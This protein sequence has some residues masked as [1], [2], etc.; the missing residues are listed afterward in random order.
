TSNLL[1]GIGTILVACLSYY[2]KLSQFVTVP[3]LLLCAYLS[4]P[5]TP[6]PKTLTACAFPIYLLHM[7]PLSLVN[8]AVKNIPLLSFLK[9]SVAGWVVVG[10]SIMMICIVMCKGMRKGMPNFS[11]LLFGGR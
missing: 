5:T 6:L 9:T 11:T 10:G 4:I 2:L 7:I 1:F 8:L 3:I